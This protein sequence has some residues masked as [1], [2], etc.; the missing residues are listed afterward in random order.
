M[1]LCSIAKNI[2]PKIIFPYIFKTKMSKTIKLM[3]NVDNVGATLMARLRNMYASPNISN[4][5][6]II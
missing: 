1:R 3:F 4:V 5:Y 6:K 2:F